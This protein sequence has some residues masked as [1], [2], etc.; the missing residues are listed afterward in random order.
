M[1]KRQAFIPLDPEMY[2]LDH[3]PVSI[4]AGWLAALNAG[5]VVA[6][7]LILVLPSRIASRVD[8]ARTMR[9]E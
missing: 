9:Y 5:A 1:Y 7:W 2:Y 6:A 8:P 4:G 3:V